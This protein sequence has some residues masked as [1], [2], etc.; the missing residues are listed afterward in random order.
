MTGPDSGGLREALETARLDLRQRIA[1]TIAPFLTGGAPNTL[2]WELLD[3]A[4]PDDLLEDAVTPHVAALLA[5]RDEA[6][7]Q[8]AA[9]RA[10]LTHDPS[11]DSYIEQQFRR[12]LGEST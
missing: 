10:L 6:V 3:E 12:A 1:G 5:E 7:R 8:V 11:L 2:A 9:V 4:W